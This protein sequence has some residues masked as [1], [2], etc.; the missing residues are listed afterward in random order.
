[1]KSNDSFSMF[2]LV[3]SLILASI[4]AQANDET[5]Y[6]LH[7]GIYPPFVQMDNNGSTDVIVQKI[8]KA[9]GVTVEVVHF[10]LKRLGTHSLGRAKN[11]GIYAP[12][13]L[14][15]AYAKKEDLL[16]SKPF[17]M[18]RFLFWYFKPNFRENIEWSQFSDLKG[19]RIATPL[20][21]LLTPKLIEAGLE[22]DFANDTD[23]HIRKLVMNRAD[24]SPLFYLT[25]H[26]SIMKYY[27]NKL[28]DFGH[29]K[30]PIAFT[31]YSLILNKGHH[32]AEDIMRH[33]HIGLD[34]IIKNGSYLQWLEEL[35]GKDG[36]PREYQDLIFKKLNYNPDINYQ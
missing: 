20:G 35:Y 5:P 9:S 8:F 1:M 2:M 14:G 32:Q 29:L 13:S 34:K 22:V 33:Y 11:L 18:G 25:A 21:S 28:Q 31:E 4:M 23:A 17:Q 12:I 3:L 7:A 10:P 19:Y 24:L 36:I 16:I 15:L 6:V 30:K 27:P 26:N